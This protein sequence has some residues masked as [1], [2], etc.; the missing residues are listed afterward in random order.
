MDRKHRNDRTVLVVSADVCLRQGVMRM[1]KSRGFHTAEAA[2][3]QELIEWCREAR[4]ALVLLDLTQ[5]PDDDRTSARLIREHANLHDTPLM[6]ISADEHRTDSALERGCVAEVFNFD[7]LI[8]LLG[9]L[10]PKPRRRRR[11]VASRS[12]LT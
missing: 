9:R 5:S 3:E 11:L 8:F 1:L 10:L 7:Q 2:D 6:I 12:T 4:P